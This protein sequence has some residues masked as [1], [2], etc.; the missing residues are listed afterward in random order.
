MVATAHGSVIVQPKGCAITGKW[1]VKPGTESHFSVPGPLQDM[2][3]RLSTV[4]LALSKAVATRGSPFARLG[5]GSAA[6]A[7]LAHQQGMSSKSQP[8]Q[9][10]PPALPT[11]A[12]PP[13]PPPTVVSPTLPDVPCAA[14]KVHAAVKEEQGPEWPLGGREGHLAREAAR[15]A[16]SKRLGQGSLAASLAE[17]ERQAEEEEPADAAPKEEPAGDFD[18]SGAPKEEPGGDSDDSGWGSWGGGSPPPENTLLERSM[19]AF[20]SAIAAEAGARSLRK[21]E[22]LGKL[23]ASASATLAAST[24]TGAS[25]EI[26][27]RKGK[28]FAEAAGLR[29]SA[30][31]EAVAFVAV[32]LASALALLDTRQL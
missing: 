2:A 21:A 29:G 25:S 18:D 3:A 20:A 16:E 12:F 32:F 15:E 26:P 24:S 7:A 1:A 10:A 27:A 8:A 28:A 5:R 17:H 13:M 23:R 19:G 9:H 22:A 30:R 11:K 14:A 6:R 31:A 4:R